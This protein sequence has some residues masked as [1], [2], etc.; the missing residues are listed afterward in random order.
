MPDLDVLVVSEDVDEACAWDEAGMPP[1]ALSGRCV[2]GRDAE[3]DEDESELDTVVCACE[4]DGFVYDGH[5]GLH[6]P[7]YIVCVCVCVCV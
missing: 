3:V 1:N 5:A 6:S 7:C 4:P 2:L